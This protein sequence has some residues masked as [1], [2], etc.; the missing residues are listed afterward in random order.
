[1]IRI[2]DASHWA[3]DK[4]SGIRRWRHRMRR[5]ILGLLLLGL[6][7][8]PVQAQ[9][10]GDVQ[11]GA[12]LARSWCANCHVVGRGPGPSPTTGDAA[13]TFASIA[14]MP[15]TTALSLR[16]FLQTPHQRMPDFMIS[17]ND[18]DDLIAY[19]LSL[20]GN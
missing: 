9:R 8:L 18:T 7:A 6:A 10:L 15:S 17:R 19:I 14:A 1:M 12:T 16:V 11:N 20:R 2:K 5:T 13:P 4:S 3:C